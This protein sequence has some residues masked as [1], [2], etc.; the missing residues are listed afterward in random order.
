M[1]L[2]IILLIMFFG[3]LIFVPLLGM[4]LVNSLPALV[5]FDLAASLSFVSRS[6]SGE[7]DM[8]VGEL[9]CQL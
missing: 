8:P 6:F 4:F 9:E 1:F 5:L 3:M 7:F 2:S